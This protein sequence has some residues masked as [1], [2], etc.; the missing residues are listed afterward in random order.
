MAAI[1]VLESVRKRHPRFQHEK[2]KI[3]SPQ[4]LIDC[5]CEDPPREKTDPD[6]GC[7]IPTV[8]KAF[9]WLKENSLQSEADY[10]YLFQPKDSLKIKDYLKIKGHERTKLLQRVA[11][12]PVAAVIDITKE[13]LA[14]KDKIYEGPAM[15]SEGDPARHAVVIIGYGRM[16]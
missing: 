2:L 4:M 16:R 8:N 5:L 14:L 10:P 7:Y 11:R 3:L 1:V 12:H 9:D 15:K 6:T 13:L